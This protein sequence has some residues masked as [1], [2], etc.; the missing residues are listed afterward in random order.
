MRKPRQK[1]RR[2]LDR[3]SADS[4][5]LLR[6]KALEVLFAIYSGDVPAGARA[7]NN[8]S[9]SESEPITAGRLLNAAR[10]FA[11]MCPDHWRNDCEAALLER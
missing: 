4:P 10:E 7:L 1:S 8:A 3:D 9:R 2:K 6:K 11:A 5:E